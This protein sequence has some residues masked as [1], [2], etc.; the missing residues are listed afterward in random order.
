MAWFKNSD[1]GETCSDTV[2]RVVVEEEDTEEDVETF[3][4]NNKE[5]KTNHKLPSQ[6]NFKGH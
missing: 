5:K 4:E 6:N 3:M 1:N 2:Q